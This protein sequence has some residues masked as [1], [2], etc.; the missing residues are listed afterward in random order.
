VIAG[1][2]TGPD[3]NFRIF[4]NPVADKAMISFELRENHSDASFNIYDLSG[5]NVYRL[6]ISGYIN[7]RYQVEFDLTALS[8]GAYLVRLFDG[9]QMQVGKLIKQ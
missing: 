2:E 4:P 5:R 6:D 3:I 8:T 1:E 9:T 7:G